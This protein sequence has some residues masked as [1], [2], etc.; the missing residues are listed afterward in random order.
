MLH[1]WVFSWSYDEF[2][3]KTAVW[4]GCLGMFFWGLQVM[5]IIAIFIYMLLLRFYM[6]TI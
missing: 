3:G 4:V 5:L 1:P 2:D 6:A